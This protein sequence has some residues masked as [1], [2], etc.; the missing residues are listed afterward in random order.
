MEPFP[1]SSEVRGDGDVTSLP[2]PWGS[3]P[4]GRPGPTITGFRP[5]RRPQSVISRSIVFSPATTLRVSGVVLGLAYFWGT[6]FL[7]LFIFAWA[8]AAEGSSFADGFALA[9][10]VVGSTA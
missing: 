7:R 4:P 1:C 8:G 9:V 3:K 5:V 2:D 6:R 10:G